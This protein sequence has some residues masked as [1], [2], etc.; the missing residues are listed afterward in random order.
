MNYKVLSW[1]A[2]SLLITLSSCAFQ[3]LVKNGSVDEKYDA[4]VKLYESGDYSRALQL[5]DQ[6][7]GAVRATEK[8]QK[9]AYLYPFCYYKQKDYTLAAYYFKR[10]TTSYPTTPEA[11]ECL[12]MSAYC[13]S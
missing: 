10:Y 6:V 2:V 4:A 9:T 1:L 3:K 12:F 7:S 8:A 5:F 11:E 13:N